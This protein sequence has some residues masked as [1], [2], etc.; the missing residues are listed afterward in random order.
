MRRAVFALLLVSLA[1]GAQA[2]FSTNALQEIA[3]KPQPNAQLPLDAPFVDEH[4]QPRTLRGILSGRPAVLVFADYTCRTLCGP[5]L[6][7]AAGGLEKSG[8]RPG[9][10]YH[11]VVI[12][13]DAKDGL[14]DATAFKSSRVGEGTPLA[15]ATV[16]LTGK[17]P[18]IDTA[19]RAAG[20]RFAYDSGEDQFAHPAAAYVLTADGHV[21]RVLSGLGLAN[22][23][24]L[25]LAL[26]DAGKGKIGTVVDQIHLL[27]Y[28]FDP[29][30]GIYT[31]SILRWLDVG[32][33][34]VVAAL[35]AG[36]GALMLRKRRAAA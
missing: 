32:G 24:D 31:A 30:K 21:A 28:G 9:E 6:A 16:M 2:H 1:T 36:V 25:R 5:I 20:Y 35:A 11:L 10:D 3:A 27:C 34:L 7:F 18:A 26:V 33:A 14:D 23:G 13:I 22:G 15:A 8:L 29:A 12:G 17:Q 4:G 19:T